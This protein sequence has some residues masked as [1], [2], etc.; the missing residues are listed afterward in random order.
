MITNES[1]NQLVDELYSKSISKPN[2]WSIKQSTNQ[3]IDDLKTNETVNK[4]IQKSISKP[5]Y[6]LSNQ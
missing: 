1:R 5:I 6:Q 4:A 3:S 2:N